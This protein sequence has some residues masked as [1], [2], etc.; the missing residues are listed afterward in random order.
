VQVAVPEGVEP[1]DEFEIDLDMA[2]AGEHAQ[3]E[4]QQQE[5]EEVSE[6]EVVEDV[7]DVDES[8]G[9]EAEGG[10]GGEEDEGGGGAGTMPLVDRVDDALDPSCTDLDLIQSLLVEVQRTN[11]RH[12]SVASLEM[13]CGVLESQAAQHEMEQPADEPQSAGPSR[14]GAPSTATETSPLP[15]KKKKKKSKSND[16]SARKQ[17]E[18]TKKKEARRLVRKDAERERQRQSKK[19]Q[20]LQGNGGSVLLSSTH[21]SR[22]DRLLD[23]LCEDLEQIQELLTDIKATEFRQVCARSS[24]FKSEGLGQPTEEQQR[25]GGEQLRASPELIARIN[26]CGVSS[27][28]LGAVRQKLR[29]HS[30]GTS[31]QDPTKVVSVVSTVAT[32]EQRRKTFHRT[33][34]FLQTI[35]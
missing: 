16:G 26:R 21:A 1:G 10:R 29:A 18:A 17:A 6:E 31:G 9:G 4:Q 19:Q 3:H 15:K 27:E 2:L 33:V 25:G 14:E 30:Y 20:Q 13:K 32:P 12:A 22:I 35:V 24:K 23:P 11:F 5:E 28:K 8:V 34:L 7:E